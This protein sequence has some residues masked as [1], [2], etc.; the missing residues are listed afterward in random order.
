[1]PVIARDLPT[2]MVAKAY[3]HWAHVYDGLCKHLF[4][5]AHVAAAE[6]A[7]RV[8]GEVLEVGVGT[9]LLLPLYSRSLRVTGVDLSPAML[10]KAQERV[11]REGLRHVQ[12]L[13]IAD[14]HSMDHPDE[15]Y[16]A[17]VFP[18]VLTLVSQPEAALDNSLRMLKPGGE[19]IIVSHFRS[20]NRYLAG[21]ESAVA[22]LIAGV[23]LRPDFPISR[24]EAWCGAKADCT[25]H[26]PEPLGLGRVYSLLRIVK[27]PRGET[28]CAG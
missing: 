18:F 10:L 3:G 23:G 28:R 14:V 13:E 15:R 7:N 9:G 24:I 21:F 11:E 26:E 19:I 22:P 17:I 6:A 27:K 16:D 8:G 20:R 1:M 5:P 2:G 4:Q 25:M 12:A